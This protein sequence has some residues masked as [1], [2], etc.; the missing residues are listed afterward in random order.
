MSYG[1]LMSLGCPPKCYVIIH[2]CEGAFILK[3]ATQVSMWFGIQAS[4]QVLKFGLSPTNVSLQ[5]AGN[6]TA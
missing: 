1:P 5:M 4:T 2:E 6:N 3:M